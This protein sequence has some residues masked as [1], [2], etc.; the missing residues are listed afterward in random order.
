LPTW[1]QGRITANLVY[2]EECAFSPTR[3]EVKLDGEVAEVALVDVAVCQDLFVVSKAIWDTRKIRQIF[4]NRTGYRF[5]FI[6]AA[7]PAPIS[8]D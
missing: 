8:E 1:H 5:S 4:L 6:V 3:V 2:L 7:C